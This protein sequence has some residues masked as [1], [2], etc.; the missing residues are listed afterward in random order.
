MSINITGGV[1]AGSQYTV[2]SD[3][4]DTILYDRVGVDQ[5]IKYVRST[6]T[7]S[8]AGDHHP[9]LFSYHDTTLDQLVTTI[10]NPINLY[11]YT[12][13]GAFKFSFVNPHRAG[14][15]FFT[16]ENEFRA[17][18]PKSSATTIITLQ[19]RG[20]FYRIKNQD[21]TITD[22]Y[23]MPT[24][25]EEVYHTTGT[26]TTEAWRP[27][28][29]GTYALELVRT[30]PLEVVMLA[31]NMVT[32]AELDAWDLANATPP[33]PPSSPVYVPPTPPSSSVYVPRS[34]R[35][36]NLNFW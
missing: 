17:F 24:T 31:V 13:G 23:G 10:V 8:D 15:S 29:G 16:L 12:L 27:P 7:W 20:L 30:N 35:G 2:F 3:D 5:R 33:T 32:Q 26:D 11:G 34:N 14:L 36:G 22:E 28:V 25:S 9:G 19:G 1:W 21:V 6:L 18:I 4:G